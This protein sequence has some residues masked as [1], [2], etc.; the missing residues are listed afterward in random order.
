MYNV[1]SLFD[2][3]DD[4]IVFEILVYVVKLRIQWY[5]QMLCTDG[6]RIPLRA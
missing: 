5:E 1:L 6:N 2:D 4:D 3:D